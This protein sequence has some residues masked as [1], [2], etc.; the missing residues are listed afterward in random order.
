MCIGCIFLQLLIKTH[1]VSACLQSW[2]ASTIAWTWLLSILYMLVFILYIAAMI[3]GL[4]WHLVPHVDEVWRSDSGGTVKRG[5]WVFWGFWV[6]FGQDLRAGCTGENDLDLCSHQYLWKICMGDAEG[7]DCGVSGGG[8]RSSWLSFSV[9]ISAW[10]MSSDSVLHHYSSKVSPPVVW[11]LR[12][13]NIF[14]VCASY[15]PY[16]RLWVSTRSFMLLTKWLM[17]YSVSEMGHCCGPNSL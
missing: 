10:D 3:I 13:V 5:L 11:C 12:P 15:F 16:C 7:D 8:C 1:W 6:F 14:L 2:V 17:N 9:R 4:S